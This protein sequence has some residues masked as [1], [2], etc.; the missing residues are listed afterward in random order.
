MCT[1]FKRYLNL[2]T[3]TVAAVESLS[4]Q[5]YRYMPDA[6]SHSPHVG[7]GGCWVRGVKAVKPP[8]IV[9]LQPPVASAAAATA[10]V[11]CF[12]FAFV[13]VYLRSCT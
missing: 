3:Y 10:V 1:K 5:R 7:R 2:R 4:L 9:F 6:A 8:E 11:V 13:V 12:C